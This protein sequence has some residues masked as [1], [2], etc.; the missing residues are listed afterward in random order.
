MSD[1]L[2]QEIFLDLLIHYKIVPEEAIY[3]PESYDNWTTLDNCVQLLNAV[4]CYTTD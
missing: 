3:D 2:T 4:R 1:P